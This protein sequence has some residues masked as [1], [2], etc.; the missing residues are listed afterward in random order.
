MA[1]AVGDAVSRQYVAVYED[2][3]AA[4]SAL[5]L[6][7]MTLVDRVISVSTTPGGART[8]PGGASYQ[9]SREQLLQAQQVAMAQQAVMEDPIALLKQA[10]AKL[11]EWLPKG[12]KRCALFVPIPHMIA[13]ARAAA[14]DP[15]APM[16]IT[17][18]RTFSTS[19]GLVHAVA[20]ATDAP[21]T[22]MG[23]PTLR[24][25]PSGSGP[26]TQDPCAAIVAVPRRLE[27]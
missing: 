12:F 9:P 23:R 4:K 26:S 17:C 16:S 27:L 24:H 8:A 21:L 6:N 2:A 15:G 19:S 22:A 14:E 7:N 13:C 11:P 3:A 25:A 1:T 10:A 20:H 18:R 5:V